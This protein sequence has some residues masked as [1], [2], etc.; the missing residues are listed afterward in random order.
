MP[1]IEDVLFRSGDLFLP[2][3]V[4]NILEYYYI[5][6]NNSILYVTNWTIVHFLSGI[7]VAWYLFGKM[8]TF[9]VYIYSFVIHTLWEIWQIIG[10]NTPI[11]TLR[12]QVDVLVDTISYMIGVLFYIHYRSRNNKK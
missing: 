4:R 9:N 7:L 6:N 12:G 1:T 3:Q 5:G 10:K 8:N 2:K 11:S